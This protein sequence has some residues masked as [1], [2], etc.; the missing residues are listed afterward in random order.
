MPMPSGTSTSEMNWLVEDGA[1][2][3]AAVVAAEE[4]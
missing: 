4:L 2:E 3:D 1:E